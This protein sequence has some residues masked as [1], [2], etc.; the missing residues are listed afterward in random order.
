MA[1]QDFCDV[2]LF[3][4]VYIYMYVGKDRATQWLQNDNSRSDDNNHSVLLV[5][6][7]LLTNMPVWAY[8]C[9]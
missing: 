6:G 3:R 9:C 7:N 5:E 2:S 4:N 8:R 1:K